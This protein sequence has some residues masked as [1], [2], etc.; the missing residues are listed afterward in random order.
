MTQEQ[1]KILKEKFKK[2]LEEARF[3][4]IKMGVIVV[5]GAIYEKVANVSR[6]CTKNDLLRITKDIKFICEKGLNADKK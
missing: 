1:E 6:E 2:E 4:G 3:L 5:S